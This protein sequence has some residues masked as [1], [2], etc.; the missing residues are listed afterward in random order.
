MEKRPVPQVSALTHAWIARVPLFIPLCADSQAAI[1]REIH[2]RKYEKGQPVV[3]EGHRPT[4]LCVLVSGLVRIYR[5]M[6]DGRVHVHHYLRPYAPFNVIAALDGRPNPT[7]AEAVI[8]SQVGWLARDALITLM[9]RDADLMQAG[10]RLL[11]LQNRGLMAR[12]A[13]LGFPAAPTP[14]AQALLHTAHFPT[15]AT[16]P[17][18]P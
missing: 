6:A 14:P 2:V 8:E 10:L 16:Y 17:L 12:I 11:T 18:D 7:S 3:L 4:G 5:M 1:D 15:H 13:D 9:S